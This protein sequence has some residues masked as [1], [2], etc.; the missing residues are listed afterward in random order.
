MAGSREL[1]KGPPALMISLP[2]GVTMVTQQSS[3]FK[4]Q[5]K[6]SPIQA[7]AVVLAGCHIYQSHTGAFCK[8]RA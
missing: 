8:K 2:A 1:R 6:L 5:V 7:L 4:A 3:G